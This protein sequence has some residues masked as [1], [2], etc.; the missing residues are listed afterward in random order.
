MTLRHAL[1]EFAQRPT[2]RI[3]AG[4]LL[5][6]VALRVPRGDWGWGD[7]LV[8]AGI[9][10]FEPFTEWLIHVH[11]LHFRPRVIAGR[12]IDPFVAQKHRRH[13]AD[14]KDLDL[15][16]IP[17]HVVRAGVVVGFVVPWLLAPT[18]EVALTASVTSFAMLLTYEW[19]HFLI[20]T[21][22]RPKR[23]LYKRVWRA[24]RLHHF[25]NENYWFGVTMHLADHVLR[26]YPARDDVEVSPTARTLA[27]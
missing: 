18:I 10:G 14:P 22:Y 8:A 27:G 2:P 11:L 15:V 19:T 21:P 7:A 24:H 5:I 4:A 13:H 25:R 26:T 6:A 1:R 9:L 12:R 17:L 23:A 20:H 16:F 3:I